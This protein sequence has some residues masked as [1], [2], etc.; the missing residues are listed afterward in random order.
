MT[1]P[2]GRY[3]GLCALCILNMNAAM[4]PL[5]G[6]NNTGSAKEAEGTMITL[7]DG[8][9]FS[10]HIGA[11]IPPGRF[12]ADVFLMFGGSAHIRDHRG[13]IAGYAVT[14]LDGT[15]LCAVHHADMWTSRRK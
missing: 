13:D 1:L 14:M 10:W 2:E 4:M 6:H 7:P 5:V 12:L 15:L 8:G 3:I 9:R 11:S